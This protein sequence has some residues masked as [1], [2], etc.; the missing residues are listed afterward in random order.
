MSKPAHWTYE[1]CADHP[2]LAQGDIIKA[3]EQVKSVL[4]EVHPDFLDGKYSAFLVLTQTC[5]LVRRGGGNC[6]SRYINLAVVRP[7]VAVLTTRLDQTCRPV[8]LGDV[9]VKGLYLTEKK[10]KAR[11]LVTRI[12]NQNEQKLGLFYLHPDVS[13]HIAQPSVAL[14]QVSIALRAREHYTALVEAR[15]GM[16]YLSHNRRAVFRSGV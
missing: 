8:K 11:Q 5:D 13:V 4:K 9:C 15:T 1:D 7:L 16:R 3:T 14:L 2:D 6:A 10:L 12:L